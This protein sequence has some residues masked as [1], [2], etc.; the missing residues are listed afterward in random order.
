MWPLTHDTQ[1][2]VSIVS[3][4]QVPSSNGLGEMMYQR[5]WGKGWI[6]ELVNDK[7]VCRTAPATLGLL[8][9]YIWAKLFSTNLVP[10]FLVYKV[11]TRE[12]QKRRI[13][14]SVQ[15]SCWADSIVIYQLL[16]FFNVQ[17]LL[18]AKQYPIQRGHLYPSLFQSDK[19]MNLTSGALQEEPSFYL[20]TVAFSIIL[21]S[22]PVKYCTHL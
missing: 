10:F 12:K 2:M 18:N 5:L 17:C 16:F 19:M 8:N 3:N 11:H 14:I 7:G 20:W 4:S 1:R 13:S 15:S 6:T 9:T 22:Q 21:V